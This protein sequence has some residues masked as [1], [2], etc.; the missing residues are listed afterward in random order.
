V[1]LE[2]EGVAIVDLTDAARAAFRAAVH[3]LVERQY[4]ELPQG[5]ARLLEAENGGAR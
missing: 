2:A 5:L 1:A 4:G 3:D